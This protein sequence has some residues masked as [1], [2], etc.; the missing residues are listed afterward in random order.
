MKSLDWYVGVMEGIFSMEDVDE[1]LRRA[2]IREYLQDLEDEAMKKYAAM[3][4]K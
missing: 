1:E 3:A 2:V 4:P